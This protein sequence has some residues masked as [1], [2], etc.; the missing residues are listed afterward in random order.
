MPVVQSTQDHRVTKSMSCS[1]EL[2]LIQEFSRSADAELAQE[3]SDMINLSYS[4]QM[5]ADAL[6]ERL[7]FSKA[8]SLDNYHAELLE[9]KES[10]ERELSTLQSKKWELDQ[11][12]GRVSGHIQAARSALS[13]HR[14]AKP[15]PKLT[16]KIDLIQWEETERSLLLKVDA[17]QREQSELNLMYADHNNDVNVVGNKL[18]VTMAEIELTWNRLQRLRGSTAVHCDP[19]TGLAS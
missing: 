7:K 17:A 18:R 2:T 5:Q 4:I 15:N 9:Q 11:E 12:Q 3:C 1:I 13:N 19:A 10:H 14:S 6:T 16:K 8:G